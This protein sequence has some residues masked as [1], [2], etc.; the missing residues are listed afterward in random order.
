[1]YLRPS[2]S[3]LKDKKSLVGVEIGV[4]R[5]VNAESMLINLDIKRLYLIDP[6]SFYSDQRNA[7]CNTTDAQN[8]ECKK[9]AHDRLDSRFSDKIVWLEMPSSKAM[10]SVEQ[11]ID[12]L[13]VDGN[14]KKE[15]V[16]ADLFNY[17]QHVK[18]GGL[19]ACHDFDF[20][21][22]HHGV[23]KFLR[24]CSLEGKVSYNC[25]MAE[26]KGGPYPTYE[27]WFYR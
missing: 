14:H 3:T 15:F 8:V 2:L 19:I 1:M 7:G 22:V 26:T 10:Y 6:Y 25:Y 13:Y 9:E 17:Y 12:L 4:D 21:D 5:G 11:E 23:I 16:Y 27:V 24:F 18:Q 20:P